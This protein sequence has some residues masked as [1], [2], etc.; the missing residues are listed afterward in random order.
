MTH[1]P[2]ACGQ[3]IS[4]MTAVPRTPDTLSPAASA[5]GALPTTPM[6][7]VVISAASAVTAVTWPGSS[8][9]SR[10]SAPLNMIGLSSRMYAMAMNVVTP[11]RN[12]RPMLL[13]RALILK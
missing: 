9:L 6:S 1:R 11:P 8:L 4:A 13:P 3:V 7:T 2:I 5:S 12:S 10:T